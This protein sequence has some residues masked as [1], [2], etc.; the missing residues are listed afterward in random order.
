MR[1]CLLY[2]QPG[3]EGYWLKNNKNKVDGIGRASCNNKCGGEGQD[4][5]GKTERKQILQG[6]VS[7]AKGFGKVLQRG[8]I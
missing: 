5:T 2:K 7:Q 4:S 6:L 1:M 3:E 8:N